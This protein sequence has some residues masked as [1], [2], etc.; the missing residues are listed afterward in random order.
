MDMPAIID[1]EACGFGPGSYPIEVGLVLPCGTPF[2]SLIHPQPEWDRW[3]TDAERAHGIRREALY[4]YGRKAPELARQLN[5]I[6]RDK[7][8]YSEA[9]TEEGGWLALLFGSARS[10]RRFRVKSLRALLSEDQAAI[11][12]PVKERVATELACARHRASLEARVLQ[13]TYARTLEI[14][15]SPLCGAA[16]TPTRL[17]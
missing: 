10:K 2:C 11:W 3:D 8:V 7:T 16:I 17:S 15:R 9:W 4:M 6:L 5:E 14:T 12:D 1:V 13:M